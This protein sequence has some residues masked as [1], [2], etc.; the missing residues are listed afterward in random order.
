MKIPS[1]KWL[2]GATVA[3]GATQADAVLVQI[4]LTGFYIAPGEFE[5]AGINDVTGDGEADFGYRGVGSSYRARN[6][7]PRNGSSSA[8]VL[9]V[10]ASS[11]DPLGLDF[12]NAGRWVRAANLD[13]D[14]YGLGGSFYDGVDGRPTKSAVVFR[15]Q[16]DAFS[17]DPIT[18]LLEVDLRNNQRRIELSRIIFDDE[19]LD[20]N[21]FLGLDE[22]SR[23]AILSR[24][25]SSVGTVDLEDV[26][27]QMSQLVAVPEPSSL[28]LLALG[29][30]GLLARRRRK[31]A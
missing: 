28:G 18:A 27:T 13:A 2:A 24:S 8:I 21:L 17:S 4:D 23:D 1:K 25:Y 14:A 9:W 7:E 3:A 6:L 11:R 20:R 29:A 19:D 26:K 16:D 22:S 5:L 10:P 15:F 12:G 30:G 31:A